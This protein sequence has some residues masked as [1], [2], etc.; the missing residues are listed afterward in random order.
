M[1]RRH[2]KPTIQK[3]TTTRL[4][5]YEI[6]IELELI[7]GNYT[8]KLYYTSEPQD[9]YSDMAIK[10]KE[11]ITGKTAQD[12]LAQ[13]SDLLSLDSEDKTGQAKAQ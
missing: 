7:P 8:A 5:L 9:R 6:N 2:S 3:T 10:S 12:V 11:I 4:T 13:V 1:F